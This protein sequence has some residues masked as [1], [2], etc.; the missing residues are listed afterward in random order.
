MLTAIQSYLC[1]FAALTLAG[2]IVG[3]AKA[4]SK[5][6]LI[7]GSI[8]GALLLISAWLV[9]TS[10][11]L[12]GLILGALTS[13]VLAGRFL[14][15][16]RKTR[17]LMPAGMMVGLSLVSLLIVSTGF[18]V[19][20]SSSDFA[21]AGKTVDLDERSVIDFT[22][23]LKSADSASAFEGLP[24]EHFERTL[25]AQERAKPVKELLG[26]PFY[27]G[28]VELK[29]EDLAAVRAVL[30]DARNY[31]RFLHEKKCGGFH[32]DWAF[33]WALGSDRFTVLICFGC[34]EV[35]LLGPGGESRHDFDDDAARSLQTLLR[36]Y[37]KNRPRGE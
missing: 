17:K 6:S 15:S 37:R 34:H 30:G 25:Y 22:G 32:P 33:E 5:A 35:K 14:P 26:Y 10:N 31:E 29:A 7:A 18:F 13:L 21:G 20:R 1:L 36:P 23:A 4:A 11:S 19:D 27:P 8:A 2:G 24:H 12:V 9:G 28:A 3:F 16:Y